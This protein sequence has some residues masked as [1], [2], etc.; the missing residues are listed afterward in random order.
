MTLRKED[1][2]DSSTEKS[3]APPT[4][5]RLARQPYSFTFERLHKGRQLRRLLSACLTR[6]VLTMVLCASV[7]LVLWQYSSR[8]AMVMAKK[9]EFNTLIVG[10]SIL[11]SLNL[12]SSLKHMA[13]TLR[14]WVLSLREW[15]P[16]EVDLVLQSE[17]MS[18]MVMLLCVSRR[19]S[20]R[21]YVLAWVAI[22]AAAQIG[23][24]TLG[25]TYNVNGADKMVPTQPGLVSVPDLSTLQTYKL[26][27]SSSSSLTS[28]GSAM[29]SQME[30]AL[31]YTANSY[32][33]VGL[34]AGINVNA[35]NAPEPG[36]LFNPDNSPISCMNTTCYSWFY[37]ATTPSASY[38]LM[39]A[40]NRSVATSSTC[41]S[42]KVTRGGSG[43]LDTITLADDRNTTLNV[44]A[45]NGPGQTTFIVDP[46]HDQHIGWSIVTALEASSSE[47]WFYRCNVSVAPV[48]NAI[49]PEHELGDTLKLMAP[50]AIALQGYGTSDLG[51]N[52]TDRIQFQS[53][54]AESLLGSACAGSNSL[55]GYQTS[56]FA[57]GVILATAQSNSNLNVTGQMP[58]KGITLDINNWSSVHL[59]L[60]LIMGLQLLFAL[61]SIVLSNMVMVR[62]HSHLGEA[63]LLRSALGH[64]SYRAVMGSERELAAMFPE[65][66]T[67][68]YVC[69]GDGVY[70]LRVR[71]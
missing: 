69:D 52:L 46:L 26:T 5:P 41:E 39:A 47:P 11:L 15:R 67:M 56:S 36:A 58:L 45:K 13:A 61:I 20:L 37:E 64:L 65:T 33:M 32:G 31:R 10:L 49:I 42:W 68:R 48:V 70:Y 1:C 62:D 22:N 57:A 18:R 2:N 8:S 7:Y 6:W 23:L 71:G 66:T 54:P 44:P 40:S 51:A 50:A 35:L 21:A 59:V 3:D 12:A 38:Y 9:K 24:A 4:P 43:D 27:S 34:A 53:Y 60:G 16:R 19:F 55:M 14:W 29:T 30:N 63:T 25:L 28:N 17:N